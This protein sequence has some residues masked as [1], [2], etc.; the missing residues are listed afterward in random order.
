MRIENLAHQAKGGV[1][2]FWAECMV[3]TTNVQYLE[4]LLSKQ[5]PPPFPS[6]S[7]GEG[8]EGVILVAATPHCELG[9]NM[10]LDIPVSILMG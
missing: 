9:S 1:Y 5:F 10:T 4:F 8:R 6:P 7:R 3:C 2:S